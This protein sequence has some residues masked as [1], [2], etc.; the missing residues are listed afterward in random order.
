MSGADSVDITQEKLS[1]GAHLP[2]H[3][4]YF[5]RA[6]RLLC[7]HQIWDLSQDKNCEL[8]AERP[9]A[10]ALK[11]VGKEGAFHTAKVV[12]TEILVAL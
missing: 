12:G 5:L 8:C 3:S 1:G 2:R 7:R 9:R 11:N 4:P 6:L 10:M